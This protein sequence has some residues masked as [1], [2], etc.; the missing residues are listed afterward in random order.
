[1]YFIVA[2]YGNIS[3]ADIERIVAYMQYALARINIDDF[4]IV[5]IIGG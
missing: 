4:Q 2:D 3:F 1:M 5:M